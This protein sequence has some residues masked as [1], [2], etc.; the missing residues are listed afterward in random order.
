MNSTRERTDNIG[1]LGMTMNKSKGHLT[2]LTLALMAALLCA[3]SGAAEARR[4]ADEFSRLRDQFVTPPPNAGTVTLY[5]LN[6][7]ITKHG[8]RQQMQALRDQCGF[9]GVAPLTFHSMKPATQPAYLS[10]DYFDVY[11]CILDTARELG[12]TV[13]FYDDC[14]FPSGSAGDQMRERHPE[15][16]LKYLARGRTTVT[17][18]GAALIQVP[19]GFLMSVVASNLDDGKSRVVTSRI[20]R[21]RYSLVAR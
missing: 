2:T 13:V 4:N 16:L 8:I 21:L 5:W 14:D 7:T 20:E 1:N 17:G 18:P 19:D 9:S 12:M 10:E 6:G 15:S 3:A 11:G